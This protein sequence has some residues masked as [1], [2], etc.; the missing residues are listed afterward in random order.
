MGAL[1]QSGRTRCLDPPPRDTEKGSGQETLRDWGKSPANKNNPRHSSSGV[2]MTFA[3]SSVRRRNPARSGVPGS[4][5]CPTCAGSRGCGA[6]EYRAPKCWEWLS[7]SSEQDRTGP[8]CSFVCRC[9]CRVVPP[10]P[11]YFLSQFPTSPHLFLTGNWGP[12]QRRG[13]ATCREGR[14]WWSQ[15]GSRCHQTSGT[16]TF[17]VTDSPGTVLVRGARLR[18][19]KAAVAL[20][21]FLHCRQG[22]MASA[23]SSALPSPRNPHPPPGWSTWRCL[24]RAASPAA[25]A[26]P[27]RVRNLIRGELPVPAE[28]RAGANP[29]A[30]QTKQRARNAA[31][32]PQER[33]A[34]LER[35]PAAPSPPR[36]HGEGRAGSGAAAAAATC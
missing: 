17:G 4:G 33:G 18:D 19:G 7:R 27:W 8:R 23:E 12:K 6:T 1:H 3:P 28:P 10:R 20:P 9:E 11:G 30:L 25:S 26:G 34:E 21:K 22:G 31:L 35:R 24:C 15:G 5:T 32:H 36:M 2:Q 13:S 16:E 29:A 14:V